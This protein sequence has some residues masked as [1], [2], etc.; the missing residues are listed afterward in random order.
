MNALATLL[1]RLAG[2][3]ADALLISAPANVRYLSGFSSPEDGR[4]LLS[5]DGA[6]LLTDGRYIAQASEESRLEVAIT[7]LGKPWHQDVAE[8]VPGK[9]LAVEADHLTQQLFEQ[10]KEKLDGKVVATSGWVAELRLLKTPAE[11]AHLREAAR[12]TDAAFSHI[13]GVIEPGLSEVE[14]A[15]KLEAFMR[16]HG[17]DGKSFEIIVASG[18]RS[19]MPHGVASQKRLAAGELVTLDFGAKVQGYHADMTRTMALGEISSELR[20][21]YDA[22]LRAQEAALAALAPGKDG[23]EIDA[24]ARGILA[25]AG[26]DGYFSHGLGHGVGLQIHEGPR[27]SKTISQVL[28]PGMTVTVEPGIYIPGL[29]GVRI[30][31]LAVITE[32]GYERLSHSDKALMVL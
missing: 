30:E 21:L 8:R 9:T 22:V 7:E 25:E 23:Q 17:A 20:R 16:Q 4:V 6:L 5:A 24:L 14:V 26:L 3:G 15:L 11:L 12:I 27:L 32:T 29:V 19:A 18:P 10:L 31:D 13:L 28:K 2:L 1:E